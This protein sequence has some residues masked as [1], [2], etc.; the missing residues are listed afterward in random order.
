MMWF[1]LIALLVSIGGLLLIDRRLKLAFWNDKK[2]TAITIGVGMAIFI[3]WDLLGIHFG[4]FFHGGS[5][6]T[7]PIRI[8]PEFPIEELF[9]LFLLCYTALLFYLGLSKW[10]RI[11]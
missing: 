5:E 6:Y 8:L 7:L 2:R 3:V 9:F 11:S 10:R 1:Y 4:I